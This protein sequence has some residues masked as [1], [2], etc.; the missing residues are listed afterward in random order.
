MASAGGT[1]YP[2]SGT[3][4]SWVTRHVAETRYHFVRDEFGNYP[5]V[6]LL[7]ALRAENRTCFFQPVGCRRLSA[8]QDRAAEVFLSTERPLA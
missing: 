8:D 3:L 1:A 5:I 7:G 2:P 6:R 4:G